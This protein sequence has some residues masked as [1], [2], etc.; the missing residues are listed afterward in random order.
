MITILLIMTSLIQYASE[1][2]RFSDLRDQLVEIEEKLDGNL[3]VYV[4]ALHDN[5]SLNY[6]ADRKWYL[7]S[8]VKV[9]IAIAILKKVEA[10]EL[11]LDDEITL[12]KSDFVDGS[13]DL[14]WQKPGTK[15]TVKT[16]L[17]KMIKN[18][19]NTAADMLIRLI[20]EKKFN[21]QIQQ[22]MMSS[23]INNITTILQ[24]R[25]D[26]YSELHE[27][28]KELSN[29][30]ILEVNKESTLPE[31]LKVLLQKMKVDKNDLK[32]KSIEEAFDRYYKRELN[33]ATLEAM[34]LLLER[35]YEGELLNSE[36]TNFLL[37]TMEGIKTGDR[38]IKA[39]L[40]NGFRFAQKTGTQ[41][42]RIVNI[43]IIYPDN[44]DKD[45]AFI[46]ATAVEEFDSFGEAEKALE[47]VGRSL[48]KVLTE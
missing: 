32:A 2:N 28:V 18:S 12:S 23:G 11:S 37:K 39:G 25:Y 27:N 29:I 36:H 16:L 45:R 6:N 4:K 8:T 17:E 13:G 42:S 30:D 47:N 44:N 7:A 24:V 33:T 22:N 38:R 15:Y 35:L 5:T 1:D 20:G 40:P 19:D 9:P 10:G 14:L 43:G 34:G 48:H 21:K 46:I 3:G 26:A 41:I 31:R